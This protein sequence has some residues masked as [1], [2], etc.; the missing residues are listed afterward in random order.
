MASAVHGLGLLTALAMGA[1]GAWLYTLSV[2]TSLVLELQEAVA[3]LVWA[4][5]VSHAGLAVLHQASGHPALKRM[6]GHGGL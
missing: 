5:V 3:N 1:T 6:F 2:P 4:Y